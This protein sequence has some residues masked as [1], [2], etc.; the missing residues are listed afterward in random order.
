MEILC[1]IL[2]IPRNIVMDLNNA[3][4]QS[5]LNFIIGYF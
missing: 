5:T 2:S 4:P 1:E 3:I